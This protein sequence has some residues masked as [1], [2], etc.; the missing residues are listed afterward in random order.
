MKCKHGAC[1]CSGNDVKADGYCS[2]ACKQG[3]MSAGKCGCGHP[4]CANH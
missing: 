4:D 3:K 2:D 1:H